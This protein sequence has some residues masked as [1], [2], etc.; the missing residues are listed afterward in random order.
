[1]SMPPEY[2][3][4]EFSVNGSDVVPSPWYYGLAILIIAIGF[5][6]FALIIYT[7]ISGASSELM[8]VVVPGEA[9]LDLKETGEYT[10]FY[11]NQTYANGKFYSSGE[12]S[13]LQ[14]HVTEKA[15]GSELSMKPSPSSFTYSFGSRIGRSI[16]AFQVERPGIYHLNAFYPSGKG[17]EVV[18]AVGHG[19]AESIF[20]SIVI[21]LASLFGSMAIAAAI[22]F[23]TYIKRKKALDRQKTEERLI[24]GRF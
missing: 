11:E 7:S 8:Q 6:I 15:T 22:V 19:F 2:Q 16:A 24:Q 1:M 12:I 21:S 23:T 9:D 20:S 13:G 3:A 5:A 17:P 14:I 4:D 18:L 10:V